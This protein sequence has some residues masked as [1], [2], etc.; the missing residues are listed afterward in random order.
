MALTDY[1]ASVMTMEVKC[2]TYLDVYCFVLI[3]SHKLMQFLSTFSVFIHITD[4]N[5]FKFQFEN[6]RFQY[7]V[8]R[9]RNTMSLNCID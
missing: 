3:D 9:R 7:A 6:F 8:S 1:Q 2:Q 4:H 5:L